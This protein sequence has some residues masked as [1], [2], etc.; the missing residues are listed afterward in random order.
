MKK[1]IQQHKKLVITTILAFVL[2][3]QAVFPTTLWPGPANMPS[4]EFSPAVPVLAATNLT[5]NPSRVSYKDIDIKVN[6]KSQKKTVIS[7][8]KQ[9]MDKYYIYKVKKDGY[10]RKKVATIKGNRTSYTIKTKKNKEYEYVVTGKKYKKGTRKV[11]RE[12]LGDAEFYSG[13]GPTVFNDCIFENGY[14]STKKIQLMCLQI[15]KGIKLDGYQIYRRE[16]GAKKFKLIKTIVVKNRKDWDS[17]SWFDKTVTARKTYD[18]KVRGYKKMGKKTVYGASEI[19]DRRA[20]RNTGAYTI[21]GDPEGDTPVL[22]ITGHKDN[23]TLDFYPNILMDVGYGS[24]KDES[25]YYQTTAISLDN[26]TWITRD[27]KN[28][29]GYMELDGADSIWIKLK[30]TELDPEEGS[31]DVYESENYFR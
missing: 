24:K 8:K 7:W 19:C 18:Y 31:G 29:W 26:K 13:V 27:S 22:K 15:P 3:L 11:I 14:T 12:C 10:S 16:K 1:I 2:A 21:T 9:K 23:G 17:I 28:A 6:V 5:A 30:K 20:V 25:I 4:S